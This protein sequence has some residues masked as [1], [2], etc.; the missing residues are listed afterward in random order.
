MKDRGLSSPDEG[1]CILAR[2]LLAHGGARNHHMAQSDPLPP[3]SYRL[4]NPHNAGALWA[5][6]NSLPEQPYPQTLPA[7]NVSSFSADQQHRHRHR[8]HRL[9]RQSVPGI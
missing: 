3:P 2:S 9:S 5:L 6:R 8:H 4:S 1:D 7:Q